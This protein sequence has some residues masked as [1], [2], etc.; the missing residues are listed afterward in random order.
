MSKKSKL[1][2]AVHSADIDGLGSAA[3]FLR[4]HKLINSKKEI[5]VFF[6]SVNEML[7]SEEE[8]DYT[9]DLP[10]TENVKINIDHHYSNYNRLI[11]ENRLSPS[12]LV[13]PSS[14]AAAKLVYEYFF[15]NDDVKKDR[16][17][18]EIRDL[19]IAA[20]SGG[21]PDEFRVLDYLIK[22]YGDSDVMLR[23]IV[24]V[25]ANN[26]YDSIKHPWILE[27]YK[28][29]RKILIKTQELVNKFFQKV[30][31]LPEILFLDTN[32]AIAGKLAKEVVLHSFSRNVVLLA[33]FS[34][35]TRD[36]MYAVSFRVRKENQNMFDVMD[37]AEKLG[38]GGHPMASAARGENQEDFIEKI[39]TELKAI[40]VN[41]GLGYKY[42][43][44]ADYIG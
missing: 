28:Q 36:K 33:I 27:K 11:N 12:D 21:L 25:I 3:L 4:F 41:H 19:S 26:G 32:G 22:W 35:S 1:V 23:K 5:K 7:T 2:I 34:Y 42:L 17:A 37:L 24:E 40:A 43:R 20:D 39:G 9:F 30:H 6:R 31:D 18:R 16:I 44:M 13:D 14:P 38:G 10:K 8:F 15:I 29:F